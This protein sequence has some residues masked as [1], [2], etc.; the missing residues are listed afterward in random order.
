MQ[1][2]GILSPVALH[3][4]EAEQRRQARCV[5]LALITTRYLGSKK[6]TL[7]GFPQRGLV[8]LGLNA[9]LSLNNG[10]MVV[11]L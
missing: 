10:D 3:C 2:L 1:H 7:S 11:P 6:T 8:T 9:T 5:G 4:V